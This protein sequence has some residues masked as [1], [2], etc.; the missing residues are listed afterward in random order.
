MKM[1]RNSRE[2]PKNVAANQNVATSAVEP[3]LKF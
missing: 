3:E 1:E 2:D